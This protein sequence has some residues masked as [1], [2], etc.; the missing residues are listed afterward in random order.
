MSTKALS[1]GVKSTSSPFRV[2]RTMRLVPR[3]SPLTACC[4]VAAMV[5]GESPDRGRRSRQGRR[6]GPGR[7]AAR[8]AEQ[9]LKDRSQF[10]LDGYPD[11][12]DDRA[13]LLLGRR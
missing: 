8:A 12:V 3:S 6:V 7:A 5:M 13:T 11:V 4:D 2:A 1:W 9:N 10:R